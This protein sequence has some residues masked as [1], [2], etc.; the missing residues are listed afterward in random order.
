MTETDLKSAV[1]SA[2]YLADSGVAA[3][4]V[5][6]SNCAKQQVLLNGR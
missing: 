5:N 2:F 1:I 3:F 4:V 6:T